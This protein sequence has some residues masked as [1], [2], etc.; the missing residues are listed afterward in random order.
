MN[1]MAPRKR[2]SSGGTNP[3]AK[4]L[5]SAA[6]QPSLVRDPVAQKLTAWFRGERVN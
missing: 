3:K 2:T 1:S 5:K 4:A 6:A